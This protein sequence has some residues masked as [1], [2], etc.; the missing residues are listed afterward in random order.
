MKCNCWIGIL[1]DY[2]QSDMNN[3]YL[4]DYISKLRR[5]SQHSIDTKAIFRGG[6]RSF[7]PR[8]YIDK[9]KGLSTLFNYCPLCGAKINWRKIKKDLT[10]P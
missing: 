7:L 8:D 3:L 2:D 4:S 6:C 10:L 9:R 5:E 1:N